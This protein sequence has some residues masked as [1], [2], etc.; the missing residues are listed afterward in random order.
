MNNAYRRFQPI[1]TTA[2][3]AVRELTTRGGV[4]ITDKKEYIEIRRME[5]VARI[6]QVGRVEWRHC[7]Y[8]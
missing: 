6:D 7:S 8:S 4:I 1:T 3:D 5:S 2:A